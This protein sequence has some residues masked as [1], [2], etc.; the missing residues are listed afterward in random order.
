MTL[1]EDIL[2]FAKIEAGLFTLNEKQFMLSD[3]LNDIRFIFGN[4]CQQKG[5]RLAVH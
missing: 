5:I 3:V 1:A 2:D 4:Q